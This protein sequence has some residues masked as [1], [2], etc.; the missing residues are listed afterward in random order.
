MVPC[1]VVVVTVLLYIRK[2]SSHLARCVAK[3]TLFRE[4]STPAFKTRSTV[5]E[6]AGNRRSRNPIKARLRATR[7]LDRIAAVRASAPI[8]VGRF[9]VRQRAPPP[10]WTRTRAGNDVISLRLWEP[11]GRHGYPAGTPTAGA[12]GVGARH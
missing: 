4:Q 9:N 11:S 12:P 10:P 2:F 7:S 1:F 3:G 8:T 6:S 5:M